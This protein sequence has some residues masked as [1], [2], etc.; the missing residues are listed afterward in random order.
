MI[1]SLKYAKELYTIEAEAI[2]NQVM[3]DHGG[4]IVNNW[5]FIPARDFI[6]IQSES[7]FYDKHKYLCNPI[8]KYTY[9]QKLPKD[10]SVKERQQ[11]PLRLLNNAISISVH[12]EEFDLLHNYDKRIKYLKVLIFS[13][14]F[15]CWSYILITSL[16]TLPHDAFQWLWTIQD[17]EEPF[18]LTNIYKSTN[19]Q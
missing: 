10:A 2:V 4:D 16:H 6:R 8:C 13:T 5:T 15:I 11:E 7:I 9:V 19:Q 3:T 14:Y 1:Y 17:M 18:S 12:I